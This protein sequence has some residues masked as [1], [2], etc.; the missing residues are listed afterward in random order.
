M[1]TVATN[2]VPL[3]KS[4]K[5]R[6]KRNKAKARKA[7][8][9]IESQPAELDPLNAHD[10][11]KIG[12]QELGFELSDINKKIDMM[13]EQG[14]DYSDI[15]AVASFMTAEK[16]KEVEKMNVE[17][18]V[19]TVETRG[20]PVSESTTRSEQDSTLAKRNSEEESKTVSTDAS[21]S[22]PK[23]SAGSNGASASNNSASASNVPL[24]VTNNGIDSE[25]TKPQPE[26]APQ[27]EV[28]ESTPTPSQNGTV[29]KK[30]RKAEPK[31]PP[32]LKT[33]L[34]IVANNED[35]TNAI[36][37]LTEW[38]VKA[39]TPNEVSTWSGMIGNR[40]N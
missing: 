25:S 8:N 34:D 27:V 1:S 36:V 28:P 30:T 11:M 4:Q 35:L 16:A 31:T 29:A 39:A 32:S 6:M 5:K 18:S 3:T 26:T 7:Q 20:S 19:K 12:L 2:N 33:K 38:I 14:L 15:N 22:V 10:A 40:R 9:A 17:A 13:W 23:D 37:A 21:F 24:T